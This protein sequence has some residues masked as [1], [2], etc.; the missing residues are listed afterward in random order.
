MDINSVEGI[1]NTYNTFVWEPIVVKQN[2]LSAACEVKK[3]KFDVL[4]K[5]KIFRLLAQ[6]YLLMKL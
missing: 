1:C 2:A 5:K 6:F 3:I 4:L